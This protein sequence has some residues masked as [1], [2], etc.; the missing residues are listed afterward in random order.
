MEWEYKTYVLDADKSFWGGKFDSSS[1]DNVL[2]QFGSE[3]WEL[4][5]T[6]ASN[7]AYGETRAVI[8]LFKRAK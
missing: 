7:K 4:V 3:G 2:N 8:F 6:V 1:L 5:N